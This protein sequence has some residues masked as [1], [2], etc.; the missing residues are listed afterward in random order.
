MLIITVY[1]TMGKRFVVRTKT[2]LTGQVFGIG[3]EQDWSDLDWSASYEDK[4]LTFDVYDTLEEVQGHIP[5]DFYDAIVHSLSG[6]NIEV[7]DI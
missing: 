2:L 3:S 7:L 1:L 4:E 6:E 5:D